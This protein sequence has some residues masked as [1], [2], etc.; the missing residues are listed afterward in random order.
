MESILG[1]RDILISVHNP[2][3]VSIFLRL[4]MVL[5]FESE[6]YIYLVM[7]Y[8]NGGDLFTMPVYRRSCTCFRVLALPECHR[9]LRA[10]NLLIGPDGHIM[11]NI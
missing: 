8:L 7:E 3:A 11:V 4:K 1:E 9:G 2:F 10:N 6:E 5:L